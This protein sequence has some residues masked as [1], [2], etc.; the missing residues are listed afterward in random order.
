MLDTHCHIDLYPNPLSVALE[1]ERASINVV[2]VTYLPSHYALAKQHLSGFTH[3][4]PALG[5]HPLA[6]KDHSKEVTKFIEMARDALLIGEIGLDFSTG[7]RSGRAVQEQSLAAI[8]PSI[9]DRPRFV[10][11]HSRGAEDEVLSHLKEAGVN[12]AVFHWFSGSKSQLKRVLDAGH[13][14]S[15]NT[16]MIRTTKWSELFPLAPRTSVLTET[17]GP[18]V[19]RGKIPNKPANVSEVLDWLAAQWRCTRSIA[20]DIVANNYSRVLS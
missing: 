13:L 14:I 1:A 11:L 8:L 15:V 20:E 3:V 2:A 4:R 7:G 16:S 19:C 6:W 9:A 5:L 18:F 17:D 12:K 10:T